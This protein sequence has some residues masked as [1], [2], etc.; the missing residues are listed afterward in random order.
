MD[1][2]AESS[3]FLQPF[4][5][6]EA[7]VTQTE[8]ATTPQSEE[9]TTPQSEEAT[10]PQSEEAKHEEPSA[11]A[12]VVEAVAM[13]S[14]GDVLVTIGDEMLSLPSK[15]AKLIA[16]QWD[17][18]SAIAGDPDFDL[19]AA[20]E[21]TPGL[22]N[23]YVATMVSHVRN[24]SAFR[25]VELD[26]GPSLKEVAIYLSSAPTETGIAASERL[27][28]VFFDKQFAT[29]EEFLLGCLGVLRVD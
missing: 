3:E 26:D 24:G 29:Q 19:R 2:I 16:A 27:R 6:A 5:A 17:G 28:A 18:W 25:Y 8:E 9:A 1:S 22:N 4:S 20:V 11:S 23:V 13:S 15:A 12:A 21:L 7:V 14:S 10:T